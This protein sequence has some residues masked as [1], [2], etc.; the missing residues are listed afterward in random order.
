MTPTTEN[1]F[2]ILFLGGAKRVSMARHFIEAGKRMGV[3]VKIYS[4]EL[5]PFVPIASVSE[6]IEGLKWSDPGIID[7][8][9]LIIS[10][11]GIKAI[12]PFVD[13][14][15]EIAAQCNV[16]GCFA[17]V[18]A[19]TLAG[20]MFDKIL[21]SEI[22]ELRNIPIPRT[23]TRG[24]PRFPLIAKPRRGSASK[25]IKIIR[26]TADFR[27]VNPSEYLIQEYIENRREY[28]VDCYVTAVGEIIAA[29]PRVRLETAGGEATRTITVDRPDIVELSHSTLHALKL[30]GA[31]TLQFIE[32]VDTGAVM[33][34]EINPRL[35]GGAVAAIAAGANLPGFIISEALGHELTPVNDWLPGTEITRY[36]QEIVFYHQ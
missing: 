20:M 3:N 5:S 4:Y 26:S 11:K 9:H 18:S 24:V 6:V 27:S 19:P 36:M 22:F 16:D 25:G 21:A 8:L 17:P 34:M 12:I 14:G 28:T 1:T 7:H 33:L 10:Q 35:G 2:P 29:V 31:V 13:G 15:V 30:T 32:D 23:Y